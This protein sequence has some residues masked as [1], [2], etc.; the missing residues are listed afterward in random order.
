MRI[1]SYNR[2]QEEDTMD[3]LH[4]Q[5]RTLDVQSSTVTKPKKGLFSTMFKISR[6]KVGCG[7][8]TIFLVVW[9]VLPV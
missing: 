4:M 9:Y 1:I 5:A 8:A 2:R 3:N 6:R 7:H